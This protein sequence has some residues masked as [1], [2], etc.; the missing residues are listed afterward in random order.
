MDN[1]SVTVQEEV[2]NVSMDRPHIVIL[3]A[4]AS[5]AGLPA[6]DANGRQLPIMDNLVDVLDLTAT[7]NEFGVTFK[8]RNFESIYSSI[9]G[10]GKYAGLV[11]ILEQKVFDYFS[12]LRLPEEPNLYDHLVLSLRP[13]DVIATFNWDPLI[14]QACVRNHERVP[15]PKVL[16]LHGNVAVGS[17]AEDRMKGPINSACPKCG[18]PHSPSKLLFPVLEK[19]YSVDPFIDAEWGT[20]RHYLKSA[21]IIT[22]FGYGAPASDVE[23][24][25]LMKDAWGPIEKREFEEIELIDIKDE[26]TLRQSW[27]G[28]IFEH[29]YRVTNN[30]YESTVALHPRRTCEAMWTNLMDAKFNE[31]HP[32]PKNVAFERLWEWYRPLIE[33]EQ[34]S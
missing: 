4:G 9:H 32:V 20:L 6:G 23:A 1:L 2:D 12:Q 27:D 34:R 28:F 30:F 21:Y 8:N 11:Q 5:K 22:I 7:L 31:E 25:K 14:F 13:K 18:K 29:H 33:V 17:C 26:E 3:G 15:L 19:N 16:Y 10:K 24:V